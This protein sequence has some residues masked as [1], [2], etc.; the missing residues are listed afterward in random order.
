VISGYLGGLGLLWK[1]A[2]EDEA[3]QKKFRGKEAS[4]EPERKEGPGLA[5]GTTSRSI[6]EKTFGERREDVFGGQNLT[7]L[8]IKKPMGRGGGTLTTILRSPK[9]ICVNEASPRSSVLTRTDL[10]ELLHRGCRGERIDRETK[11]SLLFRDYLG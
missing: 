9:E 3:D 10:P 6:G 2:Q 4:Y 7:N 1:R 11:G 8:T 5:Q